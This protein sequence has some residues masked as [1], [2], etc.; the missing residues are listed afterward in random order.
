[1]HGMHAFVQGNGDVDIENPAFDYVPA[2]LVTQ[3][4]T[5]YGGHPPSYIYRLLSDF[6]NSQDYSLL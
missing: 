4:L 3:F 1:M 2:E 6:Y 5:N